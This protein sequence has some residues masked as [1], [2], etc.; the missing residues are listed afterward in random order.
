MILFSGLCKAGSLLVQNSVS[1]DKPAVTRKSNISDYN[2]TAVNI[3]LAYS[4]QSQKS[5]KIMVYQGINN[6]TKTDVLGLVLMT[7]NIIVI[8]SLGTYYM[9]CGK[10]RNYFYYKK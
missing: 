8:V 1:F 3:V 2:M 6:K 4:I 7:G 9:V 5:D 10:V